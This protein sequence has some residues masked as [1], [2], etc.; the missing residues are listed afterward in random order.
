MNPNIFSALWTDI[1]PIVGRPS[2]AIDAL[3]R[4]MWTPYAGVAE[5]PC[6]GTLCI[7][8]GSVD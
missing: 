1:A 7:V 2:L 4:R 5:E 8:A 3:H 6:P